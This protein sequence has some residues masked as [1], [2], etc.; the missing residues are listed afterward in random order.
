MGVLWPGRISIH[1]PREGWD[2]ANTVGRSFSGIFQSTHPVRGGT[3]V[4]LKR[5]YCMIVNE[6][7]IHPPREGWDSR[8]GYTT[9]W[10]HI[11]IHPP[12]EGWD[13][14][15]TKPAPTL[16][17]SIHPPREGWDSGR[18]TT[19]TGSIGFQSTHPVRGGTPSWHGTRQP[20]SYFN[21][22]TP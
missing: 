11:S 3:P 18:T 20:N 9:M 14:G 12:R 7:S 13:T 19:W 2:P 10:M 15:L 21:P 22:P 1:P 6:I 16:T 8:G 4:R 5:P 17:I